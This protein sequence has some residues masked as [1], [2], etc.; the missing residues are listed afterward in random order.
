MRERERE[1]VR[2]RERDRQTDRQRELQ[3]FFFL[4]GCLR[5]SECGDVT[6]FAVVSAA[7]PCSDAAAAVASTLSSGSHCG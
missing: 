5:V 6:S 7:G 4:A 1:R 2:E 3:W